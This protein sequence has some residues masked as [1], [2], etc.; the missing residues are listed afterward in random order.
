MSCQTRDAYSSCS[1][2]DLMALCH[3]L[4]SIFKS[5]ELILKL[6]RTN[7][8]YHFTSPPYF[9]QLSFSLCTDYSGSFPCSVSFVKH[10]PSREEREMSEKFKITKSTMLN[11]WPIPCLSWG[12][13]LSSVHLSFKNWCCRM[14]TVVCIQLICIVLIW[15]WF[16]NWILK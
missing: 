1:P 5:V 2:Q 7:I 3:V 4:I 12:A 8:N 10:S 11:T 13:I 14:L 15:F 9:I 16:V 6:D